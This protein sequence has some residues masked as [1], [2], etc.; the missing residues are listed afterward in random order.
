MD[1]KQTLHDQQHNTAPSQQPIIPQLVAYN[2]QQ[3]QQNV[4][5]LL[6][7]V[8]GTQ[9]VLEDRVEDLQAPALSNEHTD[10]LIRADHNYG[11]TTEPSNKIPPFKF[12][13]INTKL[14][15]TAHTTI[16]LNTAS[17]SRDHTELALTSSQDIKA[18]DKQLSEQN[19]DVIVLEKDD[20]DQIALNSKQPD[21]P[22]KTTLA[23]VSIEH[24]L[25]SKHDLDETTLDP[26]MTPN[27]PPCYVILPSQNKN[28]GEDDGVGSEGNIGG[29]G[30]GVGGNGDGDSDDGIVGGGV[31]GGLDINAVCG[32]GSSGLG[33]DDDSGINSRGVASD[34][35]DV[36][37]CSRGDFEFTEEKNGTDIL[38]SLSI[39]AEV[40]VTSANTAVKQP[41][42][43][44]TAAKP[45][46]NT[47]TASEL[48]ADSMTFEEKST[49]PLISTTKTFSISSIFSSI[50][51]PPTSTFASTKI[52]D[53]TTMLIPTTT[54]TATQ[55]QTQQ[56]IKSSISPPTT[57]T[58]I[59]LK[60]ITITRP[61]TTTTPLNASTTKLPTPI[62][63]SNLFSKKQPTATK[64][65][66]STKPPTTTKTTTSRLPPQ[67]TPA[68]SCKRSISDFDEG[69]SSLMK[70]QRIVPSNHSPQQVLL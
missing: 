28:D 29:D 62:A 51:L 24:N 68:C 9:Q 61:K 44:L 46:S 65:S 32:D 66:T 26:I 27:N 5:L 20:A 22:Q 6:Q 34:G 42:D 55:D 17:L 53:A 8:P 40:H 15:T 11:V 59:P 33:Y 43:E 49:L 21:L 64:P 13:L 38:K 58:H 56:K 54:P 63:T 52:F 37:V 10:S 48:T 57:Q 18:D 69:V 47:L 4:G 41:A 50:F 36:S 12:D 23:E 16:Q 2:P 19:D 35:G 60:P 31:C 45:L 39:A 30:G 67:L 14:S 1:L 7:H 70:K 25:T 3:H